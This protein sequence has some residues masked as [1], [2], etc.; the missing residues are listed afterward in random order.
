MGDGGRCCVHVHVH[1]QGGETLVN[2]SSAANFQIEA[3]FSEK[4]KRKYLGKFMF[5]FMFMI[6][7]IICINTHTHTQRFKIGS[8]GKLIIR[9]RRPH[10]EEG[11]GNLLS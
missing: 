11:S 10:S 2:T 9:G 7:I 3:R 4:F 6:P 8:A 1:V 5:M